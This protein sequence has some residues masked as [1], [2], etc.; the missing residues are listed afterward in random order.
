MGDMDALR[1]ELATWLD[2]MDRMQRGEPWAEGE[3]MRL[4]SFH[5]RN[6]GAEGHAASAAL[7]QVL[8]LEEIYEE[9]G[10]RKE[11]RPITAQLLRLI[12]DAHEAGVA[13]RLVSKHRS[14]IARSSPVIRIGDRAVVGFLSGPIHP[15][16]LD[17]LFGRVLRECT[18][19]GAQIAVID[20]LGTNPDDDLFYRTVEGMLRTPPGDRLKLILTGIGDPDVMYGKVSSRSIDASRLALRNDVSEVIAELA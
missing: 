5:A 2:L 7:M 6:L 13:Q 19:T 15:D 8:L 10:R 3:L 1:A 11:T 17:A 16:I 20:T 14:E 9:H 18:R 12:A 4:V